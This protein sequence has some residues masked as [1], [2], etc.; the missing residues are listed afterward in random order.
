S[1]Y[2]DPLLSCVVADAERS[3]LLRWLDKT[4]NSSIALRPDTDISIIDQLQFGET[5]DHG[6]VKIAELTCNKAA[7]CID[8]AKIACFSKEDSDCHLLEPAIAFQVHGL[9]VKF[10]LTRLDHD[11]LYMMYEIGH[12]DFPSSLAQLPVFINL[13]NLNILLLVCH[14]FW[15]FCNFFFATFN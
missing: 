15:K 8:L 3:V 10:Y 9:A 5:L 13:K 2:F 6:E 11:G 14:I 1:T 4:V 7:L 12:L